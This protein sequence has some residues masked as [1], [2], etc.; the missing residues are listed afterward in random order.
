MTTM[1][2]PILRYPGAKWRLTPWLHQF[3]PHVDQVVD[4]YGGSGA[5]CLTLPY[6]PPHVVYNDLNGDLLNLFT[7]LRN[8]ITRTQLCEAI[9]FTL[10]SRAEYLS[11][12][13][14]DGSVLL[15]GE[16]VEDAR[17]FLVRSWQGQK[18]VQSSR[19]GWRNKGSRGV[20][21]GTYEVW[22]QLPDRLAAIA[23]RLQAAEIECQPALSIIGRYATPQT[24]LYCDPP[25]VRATAHGT[26][27]RIYRYEMDIDDHDA[28]L[29]ALEA[30]PGP[31]MLSGYDNDLYAARLA[32]WR[33]ERTAARGESNTRR[34]ECLWLNAACVERLRATQLTFKE[35][36]T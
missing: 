35:V 21:A 4:V 27:Q 9:C 26:R 33:C 10:W 28:L 34:T 13:A 12:V 2:A 36:I 19:A 11:C 7:V 5:F 1:P 15:S 29:T 25:Y 22:Q 20:R 14:P 3:T 32:H 23:T 18:G 17:R 16:A 8:P 30:H 31:V 6:T 24:L